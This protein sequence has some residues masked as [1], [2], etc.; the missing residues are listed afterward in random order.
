MGRQYQSW[1]LKDVEGFI[2]EKRKGWVE[3]AAEWPVGSAGRWGCV[4][5][6]GVGGSIWFMWL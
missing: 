4:L 6:G 5:W 1:E 2:G 3:R